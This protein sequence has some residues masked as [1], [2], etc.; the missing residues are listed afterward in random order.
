MGR[1]FKF[2]T[3]VVSETC[4]L[5]RGGIRQGDGFYYEVGSRKPHCRDCGRAI[6]AHGYDIAARD[7]GI[8]RGLFPGLFN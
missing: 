3:A 8:F 1:E 5:C 4:Y 7:R 2:I 6:K